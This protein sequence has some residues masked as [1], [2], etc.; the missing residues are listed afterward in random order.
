MGG[1][2]QAIDPSGKAA[3]GAV[4]DNST[5]SK[6]EDT[7]FFPNKAGGEHQLP[8]L[9]RLPE[10]AGFGKG[11]R[12]KSKR[13]KQRSADLDDGKFTPQQ[14]HGVGSQGFQPAEEGAT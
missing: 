3:H 1:V 9:D 4:A 11:R 2:D 12:R 14:G 6:S 13:S 8:N 10:L 5:S 7:V